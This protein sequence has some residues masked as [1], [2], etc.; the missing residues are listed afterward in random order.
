MRKLR[1][2]REFE[3]IFRDSHPAPKAP[4]AIGNN[5]RKYVT[6]RNFLMLVDSLRK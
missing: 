2:G 1:A 3:L 6:D 4:D 5:D